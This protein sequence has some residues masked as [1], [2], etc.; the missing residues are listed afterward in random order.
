LKSSGYYIAGI[1]YETTKAKPEVEAD[2]NYD[3]SGEG[4]FGR[5]CWEQGVRSLND[6]QRQ[7]LRLHVVDGFAFTEIAEK[8]GQSYANVRNHHYRG[9]EKLRKHL[10]GGELKGR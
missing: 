9:L 4:L 7:T 6:E 8:L 2:A 10:I 1:G 5:K 3:R